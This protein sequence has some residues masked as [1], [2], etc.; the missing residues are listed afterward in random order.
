M[1]T[2][3]P[4]EKKYRFTTFDGANNEVENYFIDCFNLK[5]AKKTA[6]NIVGNSR[7]NEVRHGRITLA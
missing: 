4:Q 6:A 2:I 3:K 7:D 5:E 1:D